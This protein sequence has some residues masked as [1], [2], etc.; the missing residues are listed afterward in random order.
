MS[1]FFV[2]DYNDAIWIVVWFDDKIKQL[3]VNILLN[4]EGPEVLTSFKFFLSRIEHGMNKCIRIR[5]DNNK[6]YFNE[7]FMKYIVE[8]DIRFESITVRNF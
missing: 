6:E 8:R 2:R 7:N 3:H 5:I 1:L 4:K